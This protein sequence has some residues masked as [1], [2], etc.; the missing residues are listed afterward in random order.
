M[1]VVAA[2]L[3]VAA[4]RVEASLENRRSIKASAWTLLIGTMIGLLPLIALSSLLGAMETV[5]LFGLG[6]SAA[7]CCVTLIAEEPRST[8][9]SKPDEKTE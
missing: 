9:K 7:L 2:G 6:L 3:M 8:G 5:V 4:K 1:A